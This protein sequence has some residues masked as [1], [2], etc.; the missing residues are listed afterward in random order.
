MIL[1]LFYSFLHFL[2]WLLEKW[3]ISQAFPHS[4]IHQAYIEH[5]LCNQALS[6]NSYSK[7][8]RAPDKLAILG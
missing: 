2:M 1:K 8:K 3:E 4:F 5:L 6:K 7:Q